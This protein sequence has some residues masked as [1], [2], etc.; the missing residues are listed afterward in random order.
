[1][2]CCRSASVFSGIH[3]GT[4][5]EVVGGSRK[6][7]KRMNAPNIQNGGNTAIANKLMS[8]H[9]RCKEKKIR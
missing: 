4:E 7:E 5:S 6:G 1:M 8:C 2:I 9:G 3:A